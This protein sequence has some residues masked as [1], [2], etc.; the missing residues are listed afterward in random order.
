MAAFAASNE[1]WYTYSRSQ[2]SFSF[3][4]K[5]NGVFA[6]VFR[7]CLISKSLKLLR[8]RFWYNKMISVRLC[9]KL[10]WQKYYKYSFYKICV[11][12]IFNFFTIIMKH[13]ATIKN[14]SVFQQNLNVH[15]TQQNSSSYF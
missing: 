6:V 14:I 10:F 2:R 8:T 12:F 5:V 11:Y 9:S 15:Y 13:K 1:Q 4:Y 3:R 7:R